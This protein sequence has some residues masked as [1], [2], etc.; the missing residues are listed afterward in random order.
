ML[1][2]VIVPAFNAAEH[3]GACLDSLSAQ[4]LAELEIIVVNDGSTDAT[5]AVV[6]DRAREDKRIQLIDTPNRGVSEARNTG[7]AL[8]TGTYVGFVDADD[9]VDPHM[10][11]SLLEPTR[12]HTYDAVACN[13]V[14]ETLGASIRETFPIRSGSYTT[15]SIATSIHPKLIGSDNLEREWPFRIVTKIFRRDCLE[16]H[17]IRFASHL[18]AAQDFT[19]SVEAML[20]AESFY[21]LKHEFAYHYRQN[22][23]SRTNTP[24]SQ[25]WQNYRS[26]DA[27]LVRVTEGSSMFLSQIELNRLHGDLSYLTYTYRGAKLRDSG[28]LYLAMRTHLRAVDRSHAYQHLNWRR[29]PPG[30]RWISRLLSRR[31]YFSVHCLLMLRALA[32][33]A[34]FRRPLRFE[35]AA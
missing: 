3:I 18:R 7:L 2:S 17:N 28:R 33:Q 10:Y 19:F 6:A 8:A 30:K 25:A 20:H 22:P 24:F 15:S 21:Y 29:T 12:V 1:L 13:L 14:H 5:A 32:R 34:N 23:A 27:E 35:D 16:L 11:A 4:E 26:I 31:Q 9:W